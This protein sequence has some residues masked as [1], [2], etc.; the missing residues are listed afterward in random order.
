MSSSEM[1]AQNTASSNFIGK[2]A[3]QPTSIPRIVLT[4]LLFTKTMGYSVILSSQKNLALGETSRSRSGSHLSN[5]LDYG[6]AGG[7]WLGVCPTQHVASMLHSDGLPSH[8]TQL[9]LRQAVG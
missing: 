5:V 1:E 6:K 2:A 9:H 8:C 7:L 4:I 3:C